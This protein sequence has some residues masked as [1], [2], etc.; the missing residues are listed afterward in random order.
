MNRRF[1]KLREVAAPT[2]MTKAAMAG[3]QVIADEA[4]RLVRVQYGTLRDSIIVSARGGLDAS[5]VSAG[6]GEIKV[7]IGPRA[8][9]GFTGHF[10]EWG[11]I[12]TA[13][14]PFM[15]PA[16]ENKK[17]EALAVMAGAIASDVVRAA[18]S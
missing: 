5:A 3:G 6:G 12:D 17:G 18:R 1:D 9:D 10:L 8:G 4:K 2:P 14:Y 16:Y 13:A 15:T 7:S 11:T